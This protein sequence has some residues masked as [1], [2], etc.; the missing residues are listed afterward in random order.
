MD[1]TGLNAK[2]VKLVYWLSII[3]S[4]IMLIIFAAV[5]GAIGALIWVAVCIISYNIQQAKKNN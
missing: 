4:I 3:I 2:G 1:S 5:G